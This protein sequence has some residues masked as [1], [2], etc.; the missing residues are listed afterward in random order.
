MSKSLILLIS[1][2]IVLSCCSQSEKEEVI[3]TTIHPVYTITKEITGDKVKVERALD[4]G[5]SPH[6]YDPTPNDYK[7][8]NN[9]AAL[10]Y[11]SD[12][13]DGWAAEMPASKKIAL[14]KLLPHN[15]KLYFNRFVENYEAK[16]VD[17][18]F[19]TDPLAVKSIAGKIADIL[20]EQIP[21]HK[22]YFNDNAKKFEHKLDSLHN[23][24]VERTRSIKDKEIF[25]F[26]PSFL[27]LISR[28]GLKYGGA[29]EKVPGAEPSPA[30]IQHF[31]EKINKSNSKVLFTEPQLPARPAETVAESADV[32]LVSLDPIGG[33]DIDTYTDLIMYNVNI[34]SNVLK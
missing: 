15:K 3:I 21:E 32:K 27:Y 14:L 28:Y 17:P 18:H 34:M 10:I 23:E 33:K 29:L 2:V 24:V 19:W 4:P 26:H 16:T 13:S 6:T 7:K 12:D 5:I 1:L 22:E 11:V 20:S 31:I 30:Y 9:S 25:L 8:A